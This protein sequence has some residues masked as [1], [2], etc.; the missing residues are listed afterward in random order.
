MLTWQL[1]TAAS[2][3]QPHGLGRGWGLCIAS[4]SPCLLA[5][6]M[7]PG[8]GWGQQ[9]LG[10]SMQRVGAGLAQALLVTQVCGAAACARVWSLRGCC[11]GWPER[12]VIYSTFL[13][14]EAVGELGLG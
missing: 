12:C 7:Q 1:G 3:V 9:G 14:A 6:S 4:L 11:R 5:A 2:T 8:W 10:C 13:Q